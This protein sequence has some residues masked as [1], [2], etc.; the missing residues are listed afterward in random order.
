LFTVVDQA[1]LVCLVA[2]SFLV[3]H[4]RLDVLTARLDAG[5][6]GGSLTLQSLPKALEVFVPQHGDDAT[7]TPAAR[8]LLSP[9]MPACWSAVSRAGR[10]APRAPP[11]F[12]PFDKP[13]DKA[14]GGG[15]VMHHPA[16]PPAEGER[17]VPPAAPDRS[18]QSGAH[19]GRIDGLRIAGQLL[20]QRSGQSPGCI[21]AADLWHGEGWQHPL[22]H[23]DLHCIEC[24]CI[25][26][27]LFP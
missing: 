14:P 9:A 15:D 23:L 26:D 19:L 27:P 25:H 4:G 3:A 8:E 10:H 7:P 11:R 21:W 5:L 1:G 18:H 20:N 17:V 13:T 24:P 2:D 12:S 16:R 22:A 6:N